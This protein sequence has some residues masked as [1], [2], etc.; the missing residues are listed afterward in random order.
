LVDSIV[1]TMPDG[2]KILTT[3]KPGVKKTDR[4]VKNLIRQYNY[5]PK[6]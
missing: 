3:T 5:E 4:V 2:R 1:V 6:Q